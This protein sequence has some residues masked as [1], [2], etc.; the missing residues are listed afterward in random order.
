MYKFENLGELDGISWKNR[1]FPC[2]N[3]FR[4]ETMESTPFYLM[5]GIHLDTKT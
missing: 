2:L 1:K 3:Y 4:K 5:R